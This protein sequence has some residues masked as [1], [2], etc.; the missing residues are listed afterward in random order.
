MLNTPVLFLIYKRPELTFLVF[1]EIKKAKPKKFYIAADGPKNETEEEF[2]S[3]AREIINFVDWD[4]E[5]KTLF[6]EENLGLKQA[7]SSAINWLFENEETGIILE[8]DC[9]PSQSFFPYCEQLLEKYKDD[10]RIMHISGENLLEQTFGD[11]SYYFSLI[12]HCWGW[13][14]WKRAWKYFD[15]EMKTY[16]E[17]K[18][19]NKIKKIFPKKHHQN[20]WMDVFDRVYNGEIN[21]WAYIWTYTILEKGG[22]CINSNYNFISNLGFSDDGTHT[23]SGHF[24]EDR[25]RVESEILKHPKKVKLNKKALNK[26]LDNVFQIPKPDTPAKRFLRKIKRE[27][28]RIVKKV[29][30]D[31]PA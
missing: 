18:N 21:S 6:R 3:K 11:G 7:V 15:I 30:K 16:P 31:E 1:E 4:C 17:F 22:L 13:A 24:L 10:E 20:Y 5:V 26:I 27:L 23:K 19:L 25:N 29:I 9:I 28:G 14:T 8:D 12:E 2:C